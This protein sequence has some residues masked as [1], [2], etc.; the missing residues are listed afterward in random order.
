MN[1]VHREKGDA[2]R[3]REVNPAR[4]QLIAALNFLR[5]PLRRV[6]KPLKRLRRRMKRPERIVLA[7]QRRLRPP[8]ALLRRIS[9]GDV[10]YVGVTGSCGKTTTTRLI[11][12][13]LSSSGDCRTD[14][15]Y[16]GVWRVA[17]NLLTVGAETNFCAQEL[18]GSRPG[19]IKTQLRVLRP[20]IGVIT[21][22]GNDHYKNFRNL[23][24]TAK[25]KGTLVEALPA[26]GTAILNQDDPHVRAMATRT[27]ARVLTYGLSPDAGIRATDVHSVWPDR[28]SLT[29]SYGKDQ[30][31]LQT[32]LVGEYWAT[33]VLAAIACGIACGLDLEDCAKAV[34][35]FQPVFGRASVHSM[36]E[37]PDYV[38][39][40]QKAPLWTIANSMSLMRAARAPRKTMVIGTV[41]DYSGKGGD[42]HRKVARQ[43]LDVADRVIFVGPQASHVA[44]LRQGDLTHRLF[45]FVTSYQA[46]AFLTES[47]IAS[48]L[49]FIKASITDH[50]ERIMLAQQGD[51]MCWQERCGKITSCPE[52]RKF[53]HY[54]PPPFGLS[55]AR[56]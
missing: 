49:I 7:W 2:E 42:T 41:S 37:G 47:A 10:T 15:G 9:R 28:L 16:N 33:S 32:Q 36:P 26:T 22:V 34:A 30:R 6:I 38:L 8:R 4:A 51:V 27:R 12:A 40:T 20:Q 39:E 23:E 43:A 29:V 17:T 48:E 24:A 35:G 1:D 25:E 50:L 21:T 46:A 19:R 52:C 55:E 53:R 18:S 45:A 44:K 54:E 5:A 11:G 56:P 14:A 3:S 31:R 13:V